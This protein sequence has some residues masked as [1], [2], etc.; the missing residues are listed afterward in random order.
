[1]AFYCNHMALHLVRENSDF[2]IYAPIIMN[3]EVLAYKERIEDV[4]VVGISHKREHLHSLVRNTYKHVE[5]II[6]IMPVALPYSVETSQVDGAVL[7]I[8]KASLLS[9]FNFSSISEE[10]YVSYCL[11]V[12][13]DII[14]T[15]AFK[16]FKTSYNRVAE[17]LN[18]VNTLK[19]YISMPEE[20]WP[21]VKIKFLSLE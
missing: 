8:T 1:M 17:T 19:G 13:K 14:G 12:R 15:K 11:V 18:D 9:D 20:F 6:E 16:Q 2:E 4:H 7:D 10:D 5:D 21:N 3:A